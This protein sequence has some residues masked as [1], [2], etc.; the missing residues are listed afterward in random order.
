MYSCTSSRTITVQGN[1]PSG[2][3]GIL[4]SSDKL[5]VA[6]VLG[7]GELGAQ[8]A[9]AQVRRPR[10]RVGLEQGLG[11]HRADVEI[12]QFLAEMRPAASTS[13]QT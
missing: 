2:A 5:F 13:E 7:L 11:N 12:V 6:D 3:Q 8:A 1:F 10:R 9:L 4:D